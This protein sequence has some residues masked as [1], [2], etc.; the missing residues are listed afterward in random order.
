MKEN[1]DCLR[2]AKL[3]IAPRRGSGIQKI[4]PN[5]RKNDN[6]ND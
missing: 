6:I 2:T 4:D 5:E 1:I 3:R